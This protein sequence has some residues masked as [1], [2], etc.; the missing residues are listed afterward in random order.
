LHRI[1]IAY[2]SVDVTPGT[3]IDEDVTFVKEHMDRLFAKH[4]LDIVPFREP[5]LKENH[6]E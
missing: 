6:K 5:L 4:K 2:G 3:I 1:L